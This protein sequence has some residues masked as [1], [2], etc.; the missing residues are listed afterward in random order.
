MYVMEYCLM[1]MF[2]CGSDGS[3]MKS[4]WSGLMIKY[5]ICYVISFYDTL[6]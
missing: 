2:M 1:Y 3:L 6:V 4:C 5:S